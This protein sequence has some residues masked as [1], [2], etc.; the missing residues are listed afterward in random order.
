[1]NIGTDSEMPSAGGTDASQSPYVEF[2]GLPFSLLSLQEV[3]G[4]LINDCGAPFRYVVTPNSYHVVMVHNDPARLLPIYRKAWLSLCDSRILHI[5]ARFDRHSIP[6]VPGS[7]LVAA[8][9]AE[10]NRRS[11]LSELRRVLIVG[12]PSGAEELLRKAYPNVILEI[13]S[14]PTGLGEDAALR[15]EVAQN[16]LN[17]SWEILLLCVGCPAQELIAYELAGLGCSSGIAL[18]VGAAIDFLTGVR[19]RAPIW[20]Q[21]LCLEWAHR[22]AQEPNRLWRRYLLES[23]KVLRIFWLKGQRANIG[24]R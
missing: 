14:A 5:L 23:P 4:R 7:D 21:R 19:V 1:M 10:L 15:L 24:I 18:C 16:C 2:L 22:L 17:R 6:A 3:L 11:P 8:L 13:L 12:P 20:M 9:M